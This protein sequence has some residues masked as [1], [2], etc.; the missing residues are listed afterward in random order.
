MNATENSGGISLIMESRI[1]CTVLTG[2]RFH[3]PK[4]DKDFMRSKWVYNAPRLFKNHFRL[5]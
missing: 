3:S 1:L 5:R 2:T 4:S